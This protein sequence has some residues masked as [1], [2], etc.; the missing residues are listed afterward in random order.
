M[1]K[2]IFY[3]LLFCSF[4]L[5]GQQCDHRNIFSPPVQSFI[6]IGHNCISDNPEFSN[7]ALAQNPSYIPD[8]ED[9][10]DLQMKTVRVNFH[11]LQQS[12]SNPQNFTDNDEAFFQKIIEERINGSLL[13]NINCPKWNMGANCFCDELLC[14]NNGT[15]DCCKKD[16]KL[17]FSLEDIIYHVDPLGWNHSVQGADI[18]ECAC[19]AGQFCDYSGYYYETY[20]TNNEDDCALNIFFYEPDQNPNLSGSDGGC[21]VGINNESL[22]HVLMKNT[23][24]QIFERTDISE[25]TKAHSIGKLLLHEMLHSLGLHHMGVNTQNDLFQSDEPTGAWDNLTNA[26]TCAPGFDQNCSNNIM[27]RLFNSSPNWLSPL[28]LAHVHRLL[29][30]SWKSKQLKI[31]FDPSKSITISQD[32]TWDYGRVIYGSINVDP[33]ARLTINCKVIM[34]P[35]GVINVYRGGELIIDGGLLTIASSRCG[36]YWTGIRAWGR[37]DFLNNAIGINSNAVSMP[38]IVRNTFE[39]GGEEISSTNV[40][41]ESI[42][43]RLN[44]GT[45]Y[46][47]EEN[48]FVGQGKKAPKGSRYTGILVRETGSGNNQIRRNTFDKSYVGNLSNGVNRDPLA[49]DSG[50]RYI[51]NEN[52]GDNTFDF[53]VPEEPLSPSFDY[54]ITRN[55]GSN[56][57]PAGNEFSYNGNNPESDFLNQSPNDIFYFHA[58]GQ[59]PANFT[60]GNVGLIN[61]LATNQCDILYPQIINPNPQSEGEARDSY[62]IG[63]EERA[64]LF[65]NLENNIDGGNTDLLLNQITQATSSNSI[66]LVSNLQTKSPWLSKEVIKATADRSDIISHSEMYDLLMANP[67]VGKSLEILSYMTSGLSPIPTNMINSISESPFVSTVRTNLEATISTK[68]ISITAAAVWLTRYYMI[69]PIVQNRDSV[70]VWMERQESIE[71]SMAMVDYWLQYSDLGE[72][73]LTLNSIPTN[74]QMSQNQQLEYNYFRNL[75]NIQ[76]D[77][78][79]QGKCAFDL[80]PNNIQSIVNIADNSKGLAGLQA[81]NILNYGFDFD[82]FDPTIFPELTEQRLERTKTVEEKNRVIAF[83]NPA[84]D[85]LNFEYH[86]DRVYSNLVIKIYNSNGKYLSGIKIPDGKDGFVNWNANSLLSGVYHYSICSNDH[87]LNTGKLVIVK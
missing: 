11:I 40:D 25:D 20:I 2:M 30:G 49:F 51:C 15:N 80:N 63:I 14:G 65:E 67:D 48:S 52:L 43:L 7:D 85:K 62:R 78:A 19:I 57:E 68:S 1:K 39:V 87:T 38:L 18:L 84:T 76:I 9:L 64:L 17:R 72:A 16:A 69:N 58:S 37:S 83:P 10:K 29:I 3:F 54:G 42:G 79:Q 36:D 81:K 44:G 33:G 4:Q 31:D 6:P 55:Q 75:K 53:C 22:N 70:K 66:Q 82:I 27:T 28:Q 24:F 8:D 23:F 74:Y 50:L 45:G 41:I 12:A 47:V 34:P 59:A 32:E 60:N 73:S 56:V 77:L 13:G 86:L 5:V 71:S 26:N 21:G 35:G 61:T 46:T